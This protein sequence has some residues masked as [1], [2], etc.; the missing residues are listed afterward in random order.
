M[1]LK[2]IAAS[3][4]PHIWNLKYHKQNLYTWYLIR[5][6]CCCWI[7]PHSTAKIITVQDVVSG[8]YFTGP[9]KPKVFKVAYYVT[10]ICWHSQQ[11]YNIHWKP[12]SLLYTQWSE[13]Q[14]LLYSMS[15][16]LDTNW[17]NTYNYALHKTRFSLLIATAC[18]ILFFMPSKNWPF[19]WQR[20]SQPVY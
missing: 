2:G 7:E 17:Y 18:S 6:M 4:L 5:S 13:V 10:E 1:Q 3:R 16:Y 19:R 12:Q 14:A 20:N 8:G 15:I 11:I 9:A